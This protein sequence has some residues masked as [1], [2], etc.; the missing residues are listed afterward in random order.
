MI[1]INS[2]AIGAEHPAYIIAEISGNHNGSFDR[3]LETVRAIAQTGANAVKLQTYRADTI[4]LDADGPDFIVPGTGP[5]AG[6]R[7]FELYDEAHTPWEWH[8]PLFEEASKLGLA[9]FST[10]FDHTAVDFL[11]ELNVP[12]YKVAS[13]ELTD[14]TLLT[15]I[16]QTGKPLIVSTGMASLEEIMHA[17]RILRGNGA[18][19][20][21][22]L[23]CTSSYPAP[24]AAMNLA[25]VPLLAAA[26]GCDVGLS[27]HSMGTTAPVVAVTLGACIVEKHFTLSRANGG[28][29]SHFSLEPAEFTQLVSDVRR[30]QEMIGRAEFGPTLAEEGNVVFRRSLY[31][32][33]DIAAGEPLTHDNVRSIRP[34]YG[35]APQ[36]MSLVMGR[37]AT[38]AIKRG[39]RID[40]TH[41][42]GS[43]SH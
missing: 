14:D 26:T 31:A 27:D 43:A 38:C 39:T 20:I 28:V 15:K 12:A 40:W 3:A 32:V 17:L 33:R 24:D 11:E 19:Q 30:A 4:T 35:L 41:V 16:A 23:K 29:D 6:R 8:A 37:A 21:A 5:W 25:T 18:D 1:K 9:I 42:M 7:L 13:F 10:P 34:G 36:Y 2:V 22:L